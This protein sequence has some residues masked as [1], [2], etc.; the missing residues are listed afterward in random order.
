[1]AIFHSESTDNEYLYVKLSNFHEWTRGEKYTN[2]IPPKHFIGEDDLQFLSVFK[3]NATN[4]NCTVFI[5]EIE[6][7][8]FF[9]IEGQNN[10]RWL[11]EK[12]VTEE[13]NYVF[14]DFG[15]ILPSGEWLNA[16]VSCL[17]TSL[18]ALGFPLHRCDLP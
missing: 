14:L 6:G 4:T 3:V 8:Y 17:V 10:P 9:D 2:Y 11:L 15:F 18:E 1:M 7:E 13:K 5:G 12:Q 16:Q